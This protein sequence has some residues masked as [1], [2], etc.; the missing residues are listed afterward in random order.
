MNDVDYDSL[1]IILSYVYNTSNA[2]LV[3]KTW[4]LNCPSYQTRI[5]VDTQEFKTVCNIFAKIQ[6]KVVLCE[7]IH[8]NGNDT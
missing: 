6:A 3:S 2:K 1:R 7:I 8:K 5:L 4:K